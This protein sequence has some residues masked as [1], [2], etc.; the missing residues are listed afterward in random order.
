MY[1]VILTVDHRNLLYNQSQIIKRQHDINSVNID[2]EDVEVPP[3]HSGITRGQEEVLGH[4]PLKALNTSTPYSHQNKRFL[5]SFLVNFV[6]LSPDTHFA[7][8]SHPINNNN[9]YNYNKLV[10]QLAIHIT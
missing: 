4:L 7:L 5:L 8:L 9:N 2:V 3:M 1:N 6:L 10:P